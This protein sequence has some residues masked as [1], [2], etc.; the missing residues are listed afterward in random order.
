MSTRSFSSLVAQL[1][2]AQAKAVR[3]MGFP[4]FLKVNMKQ[5]PRKFS[6]L[7]ASNFQ[8]GRSFQSQHLTCI[9]P[10][11]DDEYD[12]LHNA[13][14]KEWKLQKNAPEL[15][16]MPEFILAQK[17]GG[18]SFK[19]NFIIYL[20]NSFFSRSKNR[21]YSNPTVPLDKPNGQAEIPG[22]T[23][24]LDANI[25]VE[26]ED[27]SE[28]VVLDQP[29]S[30]TKKDHSMPSYSLRLGLTPQ[31]T[32]VPDLNTTAVNRELSVKKSAEKK[33]KEGDEHAS[34]KGETT[35]S[36]VQSPHNAKEPAGQ[37]KQA[38]QPVEQNEGSPST[39]SKQVT[40]NSRKPK[41]IK[42][43]LPEKH[44]EKHLG[45]ARTPE[46]LVEVRP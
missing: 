23:L 28:N 25:I 21:Y 17:D 36:K 41:L 42:E 32:S 45:A 37:S 6:N 3:S 44:D 5:I 38:L 46:T 7:Y 35:G 8:M 18:K 13:W 40:T 39:S 12:E 24:V 11:V 33:P 27:Y 14:L 16:Q 43:V 15:T 20:V 29:K 4:P 10:W 22:D 9:Q 2:E 1:N 34:K 30:I 31:N 26:K 19:R